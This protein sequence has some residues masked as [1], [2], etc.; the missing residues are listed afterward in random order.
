MSLIR[1]IAA[2][3][4][5]SQKYGAKEFYQGQESVT[6]AETSPRRVRIQRRRALAEKAAGIVAHDRILTGSNNLAIGMDNEEMLLP[7][8]REPE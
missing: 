5:L 8:V 6:S 4:A 3:L 2:L 7:S 1:V